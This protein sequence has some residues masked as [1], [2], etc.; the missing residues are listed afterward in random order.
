[1]YAIGLS[2]TPAVLFG[3]MI[4]VMLSRPNGLFGRGSAMAG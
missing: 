1:M 3:V 4:A 2:G